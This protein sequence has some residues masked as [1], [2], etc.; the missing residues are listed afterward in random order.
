M[1]HGA[2]LD[3]NTFF[4]RKPKHPYETLHILLPFCIIMQ[5]LDKILF[6]LKFH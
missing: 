3:E 5:I 4:S 1:N 6:M 2:K